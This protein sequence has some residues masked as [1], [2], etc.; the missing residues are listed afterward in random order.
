MSADSS[1]AGLQREGFKGA[2][3]FRHSRRFPASKGRRLTASK[4][5]GWIYEDLV[6]EVLIQG[7]QSRVEA[8]FREISRC[9]KPAR[10]NCADFECPISGHQCALHAPPIHTPAPTSSDYLVVLVCGSYSPFLVFFSSLYA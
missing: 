9:P 5:F 6:R 3:I 8:T 4:R 2:K 1:L 7:A 10:T